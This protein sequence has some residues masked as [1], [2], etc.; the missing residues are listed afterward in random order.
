MSKDRLLIIQNN[1]NPCVDLSQVL[2][3]EY[4]IVLVENYSKA[5]DILAKTNLLVTILNLGL[6]SM[7]GD[8][9]EIFLSLAA[10]N[11][12]NPFIKVIVA[13]EQDDRETALKAIELGAHDFFSKPV[14]VEELKVVLRRAFFIAK[15]NRRRFSGSILGNVREL[16]KWIKRAANIAEGFKITPDDLEL[17]SPYKKYEAD[18]LKEGREAFERDFIQQAIT[19]NKGNVTRAAAQLGVSR[20]TFY[21]LIEK[22]GIKKRNRRR[23]SAGRSESEAGAGGKL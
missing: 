16:E 5:L 3:E 19:R 9:D 20:A 12:Q 4:D 15:L 1:E 6:P 10:L 17:I 7:A 18:G 23:Q 13:G 8:Q 2:A 14:P 21:E 22:L 11:E